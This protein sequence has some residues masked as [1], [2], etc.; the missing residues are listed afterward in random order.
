MISEKSPNDVD[1][2]FKVWIKNV[3]ST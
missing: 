2:F 1:D 3:A